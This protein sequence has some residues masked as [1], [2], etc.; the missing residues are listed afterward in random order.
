MIA[1]I[2]VRPY[3][4][5]DASD[6]WNVKALAENWPDAVLRDYPG[7]F[8]VLSTGLGESVVIYT[9]CALACMSLLVARRYFLGAELGGPILWKW[10][11][12]AFFVCLWML[13][14]VLSIMAV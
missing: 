3:D 2:M 1:L 9:S 13:Y 14:I 10:A 6:A 4:A 12:A 11:S 7:K 5:D 8:V